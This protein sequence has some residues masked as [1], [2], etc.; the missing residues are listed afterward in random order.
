MASTYIKLDVVGME[1]TQ[2]VT[3]E[4]KRDVADLRPA[5]AA[6]YRPAFYE[7]VDAWWAD[8]GQG[9]TG[10]KWRHEKKR[11]GKWKAKHGGGALMVLPYTPHDLKGAL[12]GGTDSIYRATEREMF[13]GARA[14]YG[15]TPWGRMIIYPDAPQMFNAMSE[16]LRQHGE[17][18]GARWRGS[19]STKRMG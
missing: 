12:K 8:E 14:P 15:N 16:A 3:G 6:Y 17:E 10:G 2:Q 1:K 4:I 5:F 13:I 9:A 7:Y 19:S 18:I 11:Y